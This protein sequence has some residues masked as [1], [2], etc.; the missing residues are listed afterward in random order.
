[1][2]E[3]YLQRTTLGGLS[4]SE[5][6]PPSLEGNGMPG[7]PGLFHPGL[8]HPAQVEEWKDIVS[9]VHAKGG[10]IYA[11]LWNTGRAC[12]PHHTGMPPISASATA[13]E[14]DDVYSHPIQG[15][16]IVKYRDFPPKEF[17]E[18]IKRQI[19]DYVSAA[20]AAIEECGFDG[21]EVHGGNGYLPEQFLSSNINVRTDSY[22]GSPEKRDQFVLE[23]MDAL[24]QAIGQDKLALN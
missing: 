9:A 14:G 5:G 3:Y 10:C 16:E 11:Q 4:I 22:G 1:M 20:R 7:V 2:E 18:E 6:I 21:V 23:L 8:F 13:L 12:I 19:S 17:D 15:T 24:V